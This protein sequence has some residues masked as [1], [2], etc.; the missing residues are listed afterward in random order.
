MTVMNEPIEKTRPI[1]D[2]YFKSLRVPLSTTV[3]VAKELDVLTVRDLHIIHRFLFQFRDQLTSQVLEQSRPGK[4]FR[5]FL[6][7][8]PIRIRETVGQ[9]GLVSKQSLFFVFECK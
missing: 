4:C 9:A 5:V 1:L 2:H 7:H 3:P 8:I 6:A